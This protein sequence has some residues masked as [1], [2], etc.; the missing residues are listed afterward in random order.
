MSLKRKHHQLIAKAL[1]NL[2]ASLLEKSSC[3]FAGGTALAL[4]HGEY[5]E[6]NDM[7][8]MVSD[9]EGYRE[10]RT[11]LTGKDGIRSLARPDGCISQ[12]GEVRAD[13]YGIRGRIAV[14]GV[15]V[16]F[17]IVLEARISFELP[18]MHDK[19]CGIRTLSVL[20]LATEKMLAN[21]DRWGDVAV[22][23]RDIIDL[24]MM[25]AS[26][27][28][29][30]SAIEK[31]ESAYGDTIKRDLEKAIDRVLNKDK[32][33]DRCIAAM[34][35][36]EPKASLMQRVIALGRDAGVVARFSTAAPHPPAF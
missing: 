13:Q 9:K 12:I 11:L 22:F 31:A 26:R 23:N 10:L 33:I 18:G 25:R 29:L 16:K 24:A 15:P 21:S 36:S 1:D 19:I 17:E 5:R 7:D 28:L 3:Y 32:W 30:R 34:D 35:I 4:M 2:D 14:D 20:D 8:F 27:S 6:S